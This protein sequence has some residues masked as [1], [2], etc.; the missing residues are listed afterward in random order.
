M[1]K[2]KQA[3]SNEKA[4][5]QLT[6]KDTLNAGILE[7]L[8]EKQK[9]LKMEEEEK[10]AAAEKQKREERRQREKNK[11]FEELLNESHMDWKRFK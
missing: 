2:K 6:L 8:K 7:Q 10:K 9:K 1:K 11:S 4:Q 5:E 3:S